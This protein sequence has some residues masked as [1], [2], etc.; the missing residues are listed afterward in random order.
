MCTQQG[1]PKGQL[2]MY[3]SL[4]SRLEDPTV[5]KSFPHSDV[6]C[7]LNK[8]N[9]IRK[10]TKKSRSVHIENGMASI[11]NQLNLFITRK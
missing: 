11:T 5:D 4:D 2:E 1:V 7:V 9:Q 8:D 3:L 6:L 10:N